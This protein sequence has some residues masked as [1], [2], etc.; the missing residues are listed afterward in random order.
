[1]HT[2]SEVK[3][4][5][6]QTIL[7]PEN[8]PPEMVHPDYKTPDLHVGNNS[9]WEEMK[10]VFLNPYFAPLMAGNVTDLPQTLMI[11]MD[12]DTLTSEA[13]WYVQRLQAVGN[14]VEH[15]HLKSGFHGLGSF[16]FFKDHFVLWEKVYQ[17]LEQEL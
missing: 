1:M 7:N 15:D 10:G 9:L 2:S 6:Y 8:L 14:K 11:T 5:F 12:Q 16:N 13:T 17:Y 4:H 3:H